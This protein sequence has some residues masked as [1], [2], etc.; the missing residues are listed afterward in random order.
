MKYCLLSC[1]FL[2]ICSQ[3]AAANDP[4]H[5]PLVLLISV[6]GMK[7]EAVLDAQ[8]HGLKVPNLRGFMTDGLYASGVRGVLPTLTYPSHTTLLTGASPAKHGIFDNTTFDPLLRNARGWY[9]YAEDIK[10][11]TLWDAAAAAHLKT[12]NVYWPVSVGANITYNLPQMWR[13]G[14][15]DDLKLQRA[16]NTP[17]L[18][19]EL[20]AELGRYPGGMEETVA[21]DEVRARFAIRL[22]E[23]KHPVFLTVYLTGLDTEEHLS[24]PFS[25]KSNETLERLDAVVG[26]LR[27]AAEKAAPGRATV[28]VVSDHGF[29]SIEHDVNLY[30]A[31]REAG[32]F[33][34]DNDNKVTGWKA[35]LWPAGGSAA[36]M[37]ADPK[38]EQ[39]RLRV[40]TLLEKL[41]SDPAN[42]IDRIWTQEEIQRG[43]GFSQATFLVSLK[44]GYEMAYALSLPLITKPSNLGMHGYVPERLEMRSS[45]FIV[46]PQIAKGRSVGEIDM[47]QIAPTIANIL[48]V[49]LSGAEMAGVALH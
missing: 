28:C 15:E 21:E 23:K 4:A 12:A 33:S 25:P 36:V 38:D 9:W 5:A 35:M 31:F 19:E 11:A 27:A 8:K 40:K 48:Q 34:V 16:L 3:A 26:S 42:G 18:E 45:F 14:T 7:P 29:A 17:G 1:V 6:D 30:A 37:L 39:V 49:H 20:S 24:G 22:L 32:L 44:I 13:T 47:R 41:A 43:G 2:F 46:G 10:V